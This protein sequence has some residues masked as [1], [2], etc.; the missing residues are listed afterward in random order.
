[1]ANDSYF[2]FDNDKKMKYKYSNNPLKR[3]GSI[4]NTRPMYCMKDDRDHIKSSTNKPLF[5]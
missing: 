5:D 3:N 1:M 2:R 4:E